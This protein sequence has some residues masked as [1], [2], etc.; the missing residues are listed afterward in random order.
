VA[1]RKN[2]NLYTEALKDVPGVI[3]PL[4]ASWAAHVFHQ[5]TPQ[6]RTWVYCP[7]CIAKLRA[8]LWTHVT[9]FLAD[10]S[11]NFIELQVLAGQVTH[12]LA[13]EQNAQTNNSKG[14]TTKISNNKNGKSESEVQPIKECAETQILQYETALRGEK[15]RG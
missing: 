8:I 14:K 2:A 1:R 6:R 5:Y 11:P 15:D 3:T 12:F 13:Q 9:F 7:R 10:E 4:E